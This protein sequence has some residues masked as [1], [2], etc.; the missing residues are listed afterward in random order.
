MTITPPPPGSDAA[1]DR[2]CLCPVLDNHH[3]RGFPYGSNGTSFWID[4]ACPVHNPPDDEDSPDHDD[5][6]TDH[7]RTPR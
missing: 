7:H 3:G 4:F 5:D 1:L 6:D 2:G